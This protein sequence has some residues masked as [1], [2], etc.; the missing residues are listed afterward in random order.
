MEE[1]KE[2]IKINHKIFKRKFYGSFQSNLLY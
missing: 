1:T 2:H